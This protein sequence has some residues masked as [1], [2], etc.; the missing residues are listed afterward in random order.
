MF[1]ISLI[2]IIQIITKELRLKLD[3]NSNY[4]WSHLYS[5]DLTI[6]KD[7]LTINVYVTD[8]SAALLYCMWSDF[9]STC[10]TKEISVIAK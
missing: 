6:A 10:V 9:L 4:V 7:C 5:G 3:I 8:E 1:N 2:V